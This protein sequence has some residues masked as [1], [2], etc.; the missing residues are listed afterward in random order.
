VPGVRPALPVA[1]GGRQR[2]L[3]AARDGAP[4]GRGGAG[5][6]PVRG[7]DRP[8]PRRGPLPAPALGRHE[9]ARGDRPGAG[10]RSDD[11]ADGRAVRE[12]R[13]PDADAPPARAERDRRADP[14][15]AALRHALDPGGDPAR[16][17]RGGPEP[18]ALV[19]AGD[20]RRVGDRGP[21][22]GGVRPRPSQAARAARPGRRG[23]RG[24]RRRL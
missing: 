16:R 20:R 2:R 14:R 3:P 6:G 10:A 21:R 19:G 17:S 5:R 9:A 12:S 23:G 18:L 4:A 22:R 8:H 7:D 13:R 24:W 15:D 1:H 11:P